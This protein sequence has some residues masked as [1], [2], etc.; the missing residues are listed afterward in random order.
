M[1]AVTL[2]TIE[3]LGRGGMQEESHRCA[4]GMTIASILRIAVVGCRLQLGGTMVSCRQQAEMGE[5]PLWHGKGGGQT[6][7]KDNGL[8][9]FGFL[10]G[11]G[12]KEVGTEAEQAWQPSWPCSA[13]YPMI[14]ACSLLQRHGTR[15]PWPSLRLGE[16]AVSTVL[17]SVGSVLTRHRDDRGSRRGVLAWCRGCGSLGEG[18]GATDFVGSLVTGWQDWAE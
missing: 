16:E 13:R 10:R 14:D 4:A 2:K 7:E 17:H 15:M 18:I 8:P 5:K 1:A 6:R 3:R 9:I 12:S 11:L